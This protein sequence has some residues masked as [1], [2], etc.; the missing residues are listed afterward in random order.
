MEI[1]KGHGS[2]VIGWQPRQ[3]NE[4]NAIFKG[5]AGFVIGYLFFMLP[6]YVLPYFGSNS[7]IVGAI[8][9]AVGRGFTPQFW[10]H[11]WCL[12]M[13]VM[14][15]S[16]RGKNIGKGWLL[17]LPVLAGF[18]SVPGLN[19]ILLVSNVMHLLALV[20]GAIGSA[21]V[22]GDTE[23]PSPQIGRAHV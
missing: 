7:A 17:V 2:F 18:F 11:A 8:G 12:I 6:T 14:V 9:D 3:V 22:V 16:I 4:M 13:M 21:A 19:L 1:I 23:T 15:N 10:L 5:A 20:L